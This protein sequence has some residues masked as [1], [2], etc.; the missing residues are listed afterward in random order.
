MT[1]PFF[2]AVSLITALVMFLFPATAMADE[3]TGLLVAPKSV[4]VEGA[5]GIW[6]PTAQAECLAKRAEQAVKLEALMQ[7]QNDLI[8]RQRAQI[9]TSST[10]LTTARNLIESQR[11]RGEDLHA[12]ADKQAKALDEANSIWRAPALWTIVGAVATGVIVFLVKPSSS[13]MVVTR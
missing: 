6:I 3:C 4:V 9:A 12:L 2:A 7:A 10:A 11:L 13:A 5:D 8:T 1:R